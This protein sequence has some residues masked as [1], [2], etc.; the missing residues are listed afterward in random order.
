M[1]RLLRAGFVIALVLAA[2]PSCADFVTLDFSGTISNDTTGLF[3]AG[4]P[5]TGEVSYDSTYN[6][7][8]FDLGGSSSEH[9]IMLTVG[10]F[11]ETTPGSSFRVISGGTSFRV[12]VQA[13][14]FFGPPSAQNAYNQVE[15]DLTATSSI[16]PTTSLP[17]TQTFID[18]A[19]TLTGTASF[20]NGRSGAQRTQGPLT[21]INAV[22]EP[23]ALASLLSGGT[24]LTVGTLARA[25][26]R[27]RGE[28]RDGPDTDEA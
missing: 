4:T 20:Q 6:Q 24:I 25:R 23:A 14:N 21:T 12:L 13:L 7:A 2:R 9:L 27:R 16:F 3:P 28:G 18:A 1:R 17:G 5:F 8:G 26:R 22:P 10:N 11:T 19:S 15:L